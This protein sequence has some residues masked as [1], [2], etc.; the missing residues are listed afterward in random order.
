MKEKRISVRRTLAT[1]MLLLSLGCVGACQKPEAPGNAAEPV[2]PA[3]REP[4]A[5]PRMEVVDRGQILAAVAQ[6]ASAHALGMDDRAEQRARDGRQFEFRMRFG[7]GGP[8]PDLKADAL[9]WTL[10]AE[11]GTLR[12]A[13][14]PTLH[15]EDPL[16][17]SL[18]GDRFEAVEGFWIARPWLLRSSCPAAAADPAPP[19]EASPAEQPPA[20]APPAKAPAAD[21]PEDAPSPAIPRIGIAQY[22]SETDARIGR[23]AMRPY[24]AVKNLDPGQ[25]VGSQ[26]FDLVLSGRLKALP[27]GR[28]IAC[29]S[30]NADLPP[31][32]VVS[33]DLDRVR[34][35]VPESAEII[36][37]WRIP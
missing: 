37:E 28:V 31:E 2:E 11:S 13:A 34:I 9:A 20:K 19:A 12:V 24:E 22:F 7:C 8:S 14:R 5:V 26:G 27:D 18:A 32:C 17:K 15:I 4:I 36:A 29:K 23:R 3:P 35:E 10:D 33:A 25:S 6:A 30:A 21:P 1:S 16:V